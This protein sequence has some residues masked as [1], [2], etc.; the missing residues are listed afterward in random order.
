MLELLL[1]KWVS[2]QSL[3]EE[4]DAPPLRVV[5]QAAAEGPGWGQG[6]R[7]PPPPSV[8]VTATMTL[9]ASPRLDSASLLSPNPC[10]PSFQRQGE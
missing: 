2:Q 3:W 8:S 9:G 7:L 5:R 4:S 1:E 10:F 6:A